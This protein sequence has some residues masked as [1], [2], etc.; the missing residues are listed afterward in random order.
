MGSLMLK[1]RRSRDHLIFNMG[2]PTLVKTTFLYWDGPLFENSV[3]TWETMFE[4][5]IA[6]M[7]ADHLAP[8]NLLQ[9]QWWPT[10]I[11]GFA[12]RRGCVLDVIFSR[13]WDRRWL[14]IYSIVWPILTKYSRYPEPSKN[15]YGHGTSQEI[16]KQLKLCWEQGADSIYHLTSIRNPIVEIRRS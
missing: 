16:C 2:I 4:F 6:T 1:I 8:L 13:H 7:S 14:Y 3:S 10:S 12:H 5:P 11:W 15:K 9:P